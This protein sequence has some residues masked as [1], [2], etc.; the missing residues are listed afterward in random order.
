[1][2]RQI[3]LLPDPRSNIK[4]IQQINDQ[5]LILLQKSFKKDQYE[6][7]LVEALDYLRSELIHQHKK[8]SETPNQFSNTLIWWQD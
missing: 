1:M 8:T 2:E 4:N 3:V 7:G 6:L 5:L